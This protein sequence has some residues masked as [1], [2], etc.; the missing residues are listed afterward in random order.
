MSCG[1]VVAV[2]PFGRIVIT[3]S[4]ALAAFAVAFLYI[5]STF[6]LSCPFAY[7]VHFT[8]SRQFAF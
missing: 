5:L 3:L 7:C 6:P 8:L 4:L 2:H 1:P